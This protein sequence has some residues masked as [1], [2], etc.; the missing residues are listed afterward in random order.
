MGNETQEVSEQP[1]ARMA[2]QLAAMV[3]AAEIR[4]TQNDILKPVTTESSDALNE[5]FAALA[6]AQ[7]NIES[8]IKD[9]ENPHFR[10]RFAALD[11]VWEACR[12]PLASNGLAVVQVPRIKMVGEAKVVS[13]RTVLGHA[14]GQWTS[15]ELSAEVR[16]FL[17]QTIGSAIT[18][19]R[20]Y[21]LMAMVGVAPGDD[22]DGEATMGR[23]V[24]KPA[25]TR[26]SPT[27]GKM[28]KPVGEAASSAPIK[29]MTD[30]QRTEIK[31]LFDAVLGPDHDADQVNDL[32]MKFAGK[33]RPTSAADYTEADAEKLAVGL[34][35]M[36][37]AD[38][39][40]S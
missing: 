39:A 18:Y 17:P 21:S 12:G 14:S 6:I 26:E 38:K 22:D 15:C 10:S 13:V 25:P 28:T 30:A 20:R 32:C 7:G 5:L 16:D 4:A 3:R 27:R 33:P 8:A 36:R 11:A 40:A 9:S 1:M 35:G 24:A 31:T 19:L 2:Y 34:R 37:D 29:H 23:T